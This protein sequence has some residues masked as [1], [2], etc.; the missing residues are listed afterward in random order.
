MECVSGNCDI[1]CEGPLYTVEGCR[2]ST[3]VVS[4]V[5]GE[6]SEGLK[7]VL[8]TVKSATI[9]DSEGLKSPVLDNRQQ[10]GADLP[11]QHVRHWCLRLL[12]LHMSAG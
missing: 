2:I 5:Y 12:L 1:G 8:E 9:G 6:K 7:N 10:N 11:V 3:V 4:V